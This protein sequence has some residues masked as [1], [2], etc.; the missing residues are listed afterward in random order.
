M[1][2]RTGTQSLLD[3]PSRYQSRPMNP[4]AF[5]LAIL[6]HIGLFLGLIVLQPSPPLIPADPPLVVRTFTLDP[7]PPPEPQAETLPPPSPRSAAIYVPRPMIQPLSRP[8]TI[9][10]AVDPVPAQPAP[11]IVTEPAPDAAASPPTPPSVS[12]G[13]LSSSMIHAPPP[14]YPHES[15]RRREHGTVVLTV[16]L[17]TK[18]T[19]I[20]IRITRSSG[21]ARLDEAAHDAVRK[22]RWSPTIVNGVAAQVSGTVEIPFVLTG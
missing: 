21:Y 5:A 11:S 12:A 9:S 7:P 15:R 4:T 19:V 2:M 13:D 17:S 10:T 14:R 16:L 8:S 6:A 22:W 18:G 3:P 1:L 20:D